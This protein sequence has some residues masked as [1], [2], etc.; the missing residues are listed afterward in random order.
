MRNKKTT[1]FLS[2]AFTEII[3]VVIGILIAVSINNWNEKRKQKGE[4][5][6]ILSTIKS[7]IKNDI[8]EIDKVLEFYNDVDSIFQKIL[9]GDIKKE[10][11]TKNPRLAYLT[12][13]YPEISFNKRGIHLLEEFKSESQLPNEDLINDIIE[14]YTERMLEIKVDEELRA[15]DFEDNF[16]YW[17]NNMDWWAAYIS[18]KEIDGFVE[19]AI[20]SEDYKNRAATCRFL[21]Y[22][23]YL[24][25]L[26]LFK[27]LGTDI[28]YKIE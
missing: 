12:L 19:Y 7:D 24:P 6:N 8:E 27:E 17:K 11:Y 16:N 28:I 13:G 18:R 2:H 14:F 1:N 21:T 15:K 22:D 20:K 3:L 25:E 5:K 23:V 26:K 10:E 9:D 4:L